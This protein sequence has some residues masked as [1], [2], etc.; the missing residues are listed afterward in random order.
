[1]LSSLLLQTD[2]SLVQFVAAALTVIWAYTVFGL[3]GFGSSVLAI[4]L[5]TQLMSLRTAVPMMLFFDIVLGTIM[6]LR[7]RHHVHT[8]E[9]KRLVP[10]AMV[11]MLLGLLLLVYAPER[12]LLFVLGLFV[13]LHSTRSLLF[14]RGFSELNPRLALPLG[15]GGGMLTS[16]FGTGGPVY[17]I[18]L[19]GRLRDAAQLRATNSSLI[20][21]SAFTRLFL[22]AVA[23]LYAN[24]AI[25]ILA[26]LLMPFAFLGYLLGVGLHR[27]VPPAKVVNVVWIVLIVAGIGLLVRSIDG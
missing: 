16:M 24:A 14:K 25:F 3:T 17:A 5:L 10:G 26:A 8:G 23:G 13:L 4:P 6:G 22:F 9:L 15:V 7:N 1:M 20:V 12:P 2:L 21:L 11:G 27:R 18:Y 19:A